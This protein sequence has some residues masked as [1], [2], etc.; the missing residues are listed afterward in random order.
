M[1]IGKYIDTF[2]RDQSGP[3]QNTESIDLVIHVLIF[4]VKQLPY[5]IIF[6]DNSKYMIQFA[7]NK[8]S[9]ISYRL[10]KERQKLE[11]EYKNGIY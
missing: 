5:W 11:V 2:S 9:N 4:K 7:E 6:A 3:E 10:L 1:T 8:R